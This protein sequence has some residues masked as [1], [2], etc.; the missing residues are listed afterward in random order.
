MGNSVTSIGNDAFSYC[1]GLLS[2]TIPDSI[3]R[4]GD[5]S[6]FGSRNLGNIVIGKNVTFIGGAAFDDC[7]ALTDVYYVGSEEDWAKIEI[8]PSNDELT[9]ATFHYNYVPEE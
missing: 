5:W 1:I 8:Y 2:I 3:T 7:K 9:E 6:F 4:I